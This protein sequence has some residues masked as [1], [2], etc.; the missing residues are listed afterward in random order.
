MDGITAMAAPTERKPCDHDS[1]RLDGLLDNCCLRCG[2]DGYWHDG[3]RIDV[4]HPSGKTLIR[5]AT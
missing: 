1:A 3:Q 4:A 5:V 2:A